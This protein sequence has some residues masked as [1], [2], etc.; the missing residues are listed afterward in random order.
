MW[1]I[2][3]P[4]G[5]NPYEYNKIK[6]FTER[7]LSFSKFYKFNVHW[8]FACMCVCEGVRSPGIGAID[9]CCELPCGYW[10]LNPGPLEEQPI[11][12]EPLKRILIFHMSA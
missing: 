10:E 9:S 8:C 2:D 7:I 4:V 6:H 1:G 11:T 5:Q 12:I 3:F